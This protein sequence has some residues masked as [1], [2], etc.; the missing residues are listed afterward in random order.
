MH[1]CEPTDLLTQVTESSEQLIANIFK[2][3]NQVEELD[4]K[5]SI[6]SMIKEIERHKFN[7]PLHIYN[8]F[9]VFHSN[10]LW[11]SLKRKAAEPKNV[12]IYLFSSPEDPMHFIWKYKNRYL[13]FRRAFGAPRAE[14]FLKGYIEPYPNEKHIQS[15]VR[16]DT[17]LN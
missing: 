17:Y 5:I 14:V 16:V 4:S 10:C 8:H 13:H 2:N 3:A 7:L 6:K 11:E 12:E 1:T 9:T 15:F